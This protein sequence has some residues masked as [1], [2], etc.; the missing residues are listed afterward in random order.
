[1]NCKICNNKF[2]NKRS[3][4]QHLWQSHLMKFYDYLINICKIKHPICRYCKEKPVKFDRA[5]FNKYCSFECSHKASR[6]YMK[7]YYEEHPEEILKMSEKISKIKNVPEIKEQI[8]KTSKEIWKNKSDK[9]KEI[10]LRGY[11][12]KETIEKRRNTLINTW[13][14]ISLEE[15]KKW[16]RG[17]RSNESKS[18]NEVQEFVESLG[19]NTIKNY[20]ELGFEIDIFLPE[21]NIGIEYNGLYWHSIYSGKKNKNYHKNKYE[22]CRKNGI[23]LIQIFDD[24]WQNKKEILKSKLKNILNKSNNEKIYARK[25]IIKEIN[26]SKILYNF[27]NKNHIQGQAYGDINIGLYYNNNLVASMSFITGKLYRKKENKLFELNRYTTDNNYNIVGG[28][29]KLLK[30]FIR[31]Y[32]PQNIYSFADLR[33]TNF[34]NNLYEKLGFKLDKIMPPNYYYTK[35]YKKRLTKYSFAKKNLKKRFPEIYSDIK[36]EWQIMKEAGYDIIWDC[37]KLRY[38]LTF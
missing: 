21:Y 31:N 14:N 7:K 10:Q 17:L 27:Y 9:E 30:Y 35:N 28:A 6:K 26:D 11:N 20:R 4:I 1:M 32:N 29:G 24:E 19:I 18:Q 23:R 12:N 16:I 25:C 34:D 33:Y 37:G 36:S 2:K 13:K 15:K 22:Q 8:S 5:K 38:I 3:F